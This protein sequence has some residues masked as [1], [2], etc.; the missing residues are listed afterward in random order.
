MNNNNNDTNNNI[1]TITI[2][3]DVIPI[4]IVTM[5]FT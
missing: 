3:N 1:L 5:I 2:V 4:T